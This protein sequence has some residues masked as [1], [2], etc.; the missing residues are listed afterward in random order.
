MYARWRIFKSHD[1]AHEVTV[2]FNVDEDVV[3]CKTVNEMNF[4]MQPI[5]L[6]EL[7]PI[8][9]F[10][11]TAL[12]LMRIREEIVNKLQG[13]FSMD[14]INR[15]STGGWP[16]AKEIALYIPIRKYWPSLPTR[17]RSDGT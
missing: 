2:V 16:P 3:C 11:R 9:S 14:E 5:T 1:L 10:K 6:C 12:S 4:L 13:S 15:C 17:R 8:D 7:V